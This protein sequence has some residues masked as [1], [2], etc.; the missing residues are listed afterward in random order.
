MWATEGV[1]LKKKSKHPM[2]QY[3]PEGNV[4]IPAESNTQGS[5]VH[6]CWAMGRQSRGE[7]ERP[8]L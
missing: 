8:E 2:G 4:Q 3:K 1:N 7:S 6:F 5:T